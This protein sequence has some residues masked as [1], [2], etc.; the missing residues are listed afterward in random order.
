MRSMDVCAIENYTRTMACIEGIK[1]WGPE[2]A[3]AKAPE[4]KEAKVSAEDQAAQEARTR[5]AAMSYRLLFTTLT[6]ALAPTYRD[7]WQAIVRKIYDDPTVDKM[8]SDSVAHLPTNPYLDDAGC[9]HYFTRNLDSLSALY[10]LRVVE[11]ARAHKEAAE[12]LNAAIDA[13]DSPIKCSEWKAGH[14][15]GQ[16]PTRPDIE[17]ADRVRHYYRLCNIYNHTIPVDLVKEHREVMQDPKHAAVWHSRATVIKAAAQ[18]DATKYAN[19]ATLMANIRDAM[20]V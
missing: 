18:P 6:D 1:T 9:L 16:P 10:D 19:Y 5:R 11:A 8:W 20:R 14:D 12:A 7:H 15:A 3:E 2:P 13:K 17:E 4:V